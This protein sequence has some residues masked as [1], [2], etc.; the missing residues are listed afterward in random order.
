MLAQTDLRICRYKKLQS[1]APHAHDE[2]SMGIV[3]HGGFLERIGNGERDYGRGHVAFV[4]AG[5]MHSQLFGAAGARQIIFRPP[6]SWLDYLADCGTKLADAPH[7]G[8]PP[9]RHLADR[10][11]AE[12]HNNDGFS[13]V[14]REG[15]LLEIVAAFGRT[16]I[17]GAA[18][19]TPPPWLRAARDFLHDNACAPLSLA[20]IARAAGRH[21]IHLAR[22]FRR[23]YGVS[24]GTYAR[25]LRV[26]K[27][28]RLLA[29]SM[30][31]ISAIALDCGSAAILICAAHS[32]H[33]SGSR[34][35]S[36]VRRE[37]FS[38][39]DSTLTQV[40]PFRAERL[41]RS[42][43]ACSTA[44]RASGPCKAHPRPGRSAN[45]RAAPRLKRAG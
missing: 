42:R 15:I 25:Q 24:V 19:A 1:M 20:E 35:R 18:R 45:R 33:I 27:A 26:E 43:P 3:V 9:F 7:S 13:A 2:A 40:L 21:E 4:P 14:A 29:M 38:R 6:N 41:R 17:A 39:A 32:R 8:A 36:T 5:V 30:I 16:G 44:G 34:P 11:F 12:M 10:L 23:Y 28:A 37:K 22:E 31:G